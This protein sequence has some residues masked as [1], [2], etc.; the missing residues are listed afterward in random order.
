LSSLGLKARAI[1]PSPTVMVSSRVAAKLAWIP[2]TLKKYQNENISI[3]PINTC[4]GFTDL[5]PMTFGINAIL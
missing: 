4:A 3:R 5:I 2:E 1:G